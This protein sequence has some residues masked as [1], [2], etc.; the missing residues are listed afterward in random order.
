MK[1]YWLIHLKD[2]IA[3][4]KPKNFKRLLKLMKKKNREILIN[5]FIR[6]FY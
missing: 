1:I 4:L 3:R 6:I 5:L 2:S